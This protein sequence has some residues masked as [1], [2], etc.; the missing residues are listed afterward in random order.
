MLEQTG[1]KA[2]AIETY[3]RFLRDLA[4]STRVDEVRARLALLGV[5]A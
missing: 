4:F 5:S 2:G 3:K 1:D